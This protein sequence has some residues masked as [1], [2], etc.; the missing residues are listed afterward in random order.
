MNDHELNTSSRVMHENRVRD[1]C[2]N[3]SGCKGYEFVYDTVVKKLSPTE[4]A[5][6]INKIRA[7]MANGRLEATGL[8]DEQIAEKL[9]ESDEAIRLFATNS[10]PVIFRK[11]TNRDTPATVISNIFKIIEVQREIHAKTVDEDVAMSSLQ[12]HLLQQCMSSSPPPT[13]PHRV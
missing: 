7:L 1:H 3:T 2:A 9:I 6:L 12:A 11:I 13:Q 4:V 10:H 8:S 5:G